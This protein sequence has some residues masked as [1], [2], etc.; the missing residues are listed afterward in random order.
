MLCYVVLF[1]A[2]L[3]ISV[4]TESADAMIAFVRHMLILAAGI[5][6]L[7]SSLLLGARKVPRGKIWGNSPAGCAFIGLGLTAFG[8]LNVLQTGIPFGIYFILLILS[9]LFLV[10]LAIEYRTREQ[11]VLF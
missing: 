2:E 6:G 1:A 10:G 9:L 3:V 11:S 7:I 5:F 8:L 4:L